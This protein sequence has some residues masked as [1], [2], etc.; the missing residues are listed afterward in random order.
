MRP[1][2]GGGSASDHDKESLNLRVALGLELLMLEHPSALVRGHAAGWH[3]LAKL[4]LRFEQ[5]SS[6]VIN[7]FITHSYGG[8]DFTVCLGSVLRDKHPD[9]SKQRPR[10]VWGIL[11]GCL[12]GDAPRRELAATLEGAAGSR[13]LLLDTDSPSGDPS[14]PRATRFVCSPIS[15][16]WR[17]TMSL[18]GLLRLIGMPPELVRL[19]KPHAA[20]RFLLN[21]AEA[22]PDAFT[23]VQAN[24]LGRFSQSTAQQPDLEPVE[25]ML[26]Q[27]ELAA[28]VLPSIYAGKAKVSRAF[29]LLARAQLV[30]ERA[31]QRALGDPSCLPHTGGWSADGPF[32][33]PMPPP[34]PE[35]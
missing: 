27:H 13:S 35:W 6:C 31:A 3:A 8:R 19:H 17:A 20:K 25:A 18:Q 34:T 21:V 12:S 4:V 11:D 2:R 22:S 28:A 24:A 5:G 1:Y 15:S 26:R 32:A 30:L 16:H 9:P 29:D 33:A 10:P 7:S 23:D 14:H